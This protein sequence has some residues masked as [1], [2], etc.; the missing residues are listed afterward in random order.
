MQ[1]MVCGKCGA[2]WA[3][4]DMLTVEQRREVAATVRAGNMIAA[5]RQVR[6]LAPISLVDAQRIVI[7]I[8]RVPERCHRCKQPLEGAPV[9]HCIHCRALNYDW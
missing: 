4:P 6:E 1:S 8:T 9:S 5:M 3:E 2:S 7:H